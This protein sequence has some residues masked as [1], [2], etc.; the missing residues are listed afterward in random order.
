MAAEDFAADFSWDSTVR[1]Q[2]I[3]VTLTFGDNVGLVNAQAGS[4]LVR[5]LAADGQ[6]ATVT[7]FR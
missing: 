1:E 5:I 7:D 3:E 6:E 2:D 4:V